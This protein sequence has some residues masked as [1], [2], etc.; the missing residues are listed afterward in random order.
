MAKLDITN[1]PRELDE[2]IAAS[3][4]AR[5]RQI[6]EVV[7]RHYLLELTGRGGELFDQDM[8]VENPVY[9]L[10]INGLSLTLRS[11]KE[12]D[13]FYESQHGLML[14]ATDVTQVV[15]DH[16]YWAE[17]WFNWYLTGA[18][19]AAQGVAVSSPEATYIKK[20]WIS[21]FWPFDE[22]GRMLGEHVYEHAAIAEIVPIPEEDFITL[23]YAKEVLTPLLRPLPVYLP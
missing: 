9:Y 7:R 1:I 11:A 19:L 14:A 4:S 10:N 20:S 5:H 3:G 23:E 21:M 18:A 8:M 2:I 16:G 13:A 22:R 17:C 12:V 6:A 15:N